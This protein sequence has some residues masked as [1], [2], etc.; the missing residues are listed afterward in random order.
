MVD[1]AET[2]ETTDWDPG[3]GSVLSILAL[4]FLVIACW[5]ALNKFEE[6]L[7]KFHYPWE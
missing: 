5:V 2:S 1:P 7:A 3:P 6:K 4:T